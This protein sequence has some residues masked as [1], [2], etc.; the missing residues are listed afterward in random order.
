MESGTVKV[1]FTANNPGDYKE[2]VAITG[3][4]QSR[5]S[6]SFNYT[7]V[8]IMP[9]SSAFLRM[10]WN[11][12]KVVPANYTVFL[13][14][15]P[16][17]GESVRLYPGN[18]AVAGNVTVRCVPADLDCDGRVD[19]LDL[20]RVALKY[21]YTVLPE[22]VDRDCKIDILDLSIVAIHYGTKVGDPNY[23]APADVNGDGRI[24]ILDLSAVAVRYGA[25]VG[26]EDVNHDCSVGL[27]DL[28]FVALWYGFGV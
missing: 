26:P 28:A 7:T 19:L 25:T 15:L 18:T 9:G 3:Y 2:N 16:V 20:S 4:Y 27:D 24:D 12:S 10:S 22:D 6:L 5:T 23:Y 13:Y 21:G 17:P 8:S 1:N 14:A 11:T